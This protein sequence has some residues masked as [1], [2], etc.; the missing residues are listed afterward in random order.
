MWPQI[1]PMETTVHLQPGRGR[2]LLHEN[3]AEE[4]KIHL[5]QMKRTQRQRSELPLNA[6][7]NG[8]LIKPGEKGDQNLESVNEP[9]KFSVV[10]IVD[11][12]SSLKCL[13]K[14]RKKKKDSVV[15]LSQHKIVGGGSF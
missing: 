8:I 4:R 7:V 1:N 6:T 12:L 9:L 14:T 15:C 11:L 10:L 3:P 13:R 2:G 5:K